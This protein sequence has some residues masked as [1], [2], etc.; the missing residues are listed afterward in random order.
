[1]PIKFTVSRSDI[2]VEASYQRAQIGLFRD[3]VRLVER[4]IERLT[5]H[6]VK[7]SDIKIERGNGSLGDLH[8]LCYLFDYLLTIR[9]RLDRAEIYCSH[10]TEDNRKQVVSAGIDT[11]VTLRDAIG[12]DYRAYGAA[13][14]LHG[15]LENQPARTFIGR[16]IAPTPAQLGPLTGNAVAYYLSPTLDGRIAG[17]LTLD[18]S[19]LVPDGLFARPLATWDAS[20][21]ALDQ[22]PVRAEEFVR[23]ALGA[24]GIELPTP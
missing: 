15:T 6:G 18:A 2:T 14:N 7:L 11:L 13:L 16:L 4:L 21:V 10:L 9:V 23:Q 5:P 20:R 1:M 22:L 12:G 3:S 24:F 8:L 19:A 17:S